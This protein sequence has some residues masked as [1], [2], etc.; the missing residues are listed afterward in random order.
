MPP[1]RSPHSLN[2]WTVA[3]F[4]RSL[5]VFV[6]LSGFDSTNNRWTSSDT[7]DSQSLKV[8]QIVLLSDSPFITTRRREEKS[9]PP[10]SKSGTPRS[11]SSL[12]SILS[13]T[14]S[15]S[16]TIFR[17]ARSSSKLFSPVNS[18]I[19]PISIAHV[20]HYVAVLR[21]CFAANRPQ[22]LACHQS[23]K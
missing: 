14:P 19:I 3:A 7:R 11:S 12:P 5:Y 17:S 21:R 23:P 9:V 10:I 15:K 18:V 22:S 6:R 20:T 16:S 8:G 13:T 2:S 4:W 1:S